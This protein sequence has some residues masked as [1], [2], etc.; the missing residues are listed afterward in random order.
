VST[1]HVFHF[2]RV[3]VGPAADDHVALAADE[4]VIAVRIATSQ[5]AL[6]GPRAAERFGR[7]L[8][9]LPIPVERVWGARE[10]LA[11]LAIRDF[12]TVRVEEPDRAAAS[13]LTPAPERILSTPSGSKLRLSSITHAAPR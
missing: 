10:Q 9:V 12:V 3:D 13:P 8:R 6:R 7:L 2:C 4:P 11:D 5:V 1:D